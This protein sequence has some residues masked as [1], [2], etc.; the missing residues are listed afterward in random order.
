M[1]ARAA[2]MTRAVACVACVVARVCSGVCDGLRSCGVCGG[3]R[4]RRVC[5]SCV[6]CA[7][8]G[9]S[10]GTAGWR[11]APSIGSGMCDRSQ[12]RACKQ[13]CK[14]QDVSHKPP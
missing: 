3:V 12:M 5:D 2:A 11:L 7:V 14:D 1:R 13:Q 6:V 10:S 9:G 4:V 8:K